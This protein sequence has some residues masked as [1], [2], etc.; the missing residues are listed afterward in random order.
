MVEIVSFPMTIGDFPESYVV[1]SPRGSHILHGYTCDVHFGDP[2]SSK[3]PP[4]NSLRE[5]PLE[6][7]RAR[8]PWEVSARE[9][10]DI[11]AGPPEDSA[12][13]HPKNPALFFLGISSR[14]AEVKWATCHKPTIWEWFIETI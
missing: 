2:K 13:Q 9:A 5:F 11:S 7:W 1:K 8:L 6:S 4:Q 3:N 10:V 12:R 14:F